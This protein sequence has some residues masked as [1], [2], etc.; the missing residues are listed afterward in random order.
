MTAGEAIDLLKS[1]KVPDNSLL[2]YGNGRSYGD[3]CQ[4]LT[5][6]VVDMRS[7]KS[8]RAFD[9][10]TGLLEADAGM[11]LSDVIGFA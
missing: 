10:E 3:S 7:L 4:N 1:G 11:L 5:G 8:L 6:T 9:P 2:G